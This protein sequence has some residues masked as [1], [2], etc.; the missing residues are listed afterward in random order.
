MARPCWN[1]LACRG[2][3]VLEA[4]CEH[5]NILTPDGDKCDQLFV[6]DDGTVVLDSQAGKMASLPV[7]TKLRSN[8]CGCQVDV[9]VDVDR[10]V[11]WLSELCV[12]KVDID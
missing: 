12:R 3:R 8:E 9:L 7:K 2:F 10:R 5:G 1:W 11:Y 4:T 6:H